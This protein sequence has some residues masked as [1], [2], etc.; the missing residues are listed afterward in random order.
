MLSE[1]IQDPNI[2]SSGDYSI[3]VVPSAG[4]DARRPPLGTPRLYGSA[5]VT[6]SLATIPIY[7]AIAKG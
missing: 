6:W 4:M 5:T 2:T 3:S 7:L 1:P